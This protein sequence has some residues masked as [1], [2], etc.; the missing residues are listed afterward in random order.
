MWATTLLG[1]C[2]VDRGFL[3]E[4]I[5]SSYGIPLPVLALS[6]GIILFL[7]ALKSVLEQ[8]ETPEP[9]TNDVRFRRQRR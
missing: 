9:H 8:F 7:V 3:G 2:T 5:L 6:G 1:I 4:N